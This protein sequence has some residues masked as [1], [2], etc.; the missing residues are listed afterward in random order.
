MR[1]FALLKWIAVGCLGFGWVVPLQAVQLQ[2]GKTYFVQPPRLV[3]TSANFL[4]AT[5]SGVTYAFTLDLPA[6]AGEP[7]Q[8]V[9][10]VQASG[11]D[12]PDF[13]HLNQSQLLIRSPQK[14]GTPV[15]L[16]AITA[17]AKTGSLSIWFD[18]PILPGQTITLELAPIC[19]PSVQGTYLFGVTAFPV[20][21]NAHGQF[22]G[23]GRFQIRR[24]RGV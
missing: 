16:K 20:G 7:L 13:S 1:G 17:N 5:L 8:R 15:A 11:S 24:T 6:N 2:D 14:A 18:P 22:L 12:R 10:I 19:N 9:T 23:F 4:T 21:A 3:S